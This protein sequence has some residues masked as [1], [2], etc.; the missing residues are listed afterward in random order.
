[1]KTNTFQLKSN[2]QEFETGHIVKNGHP[3]GTRFRKAFSYSNFVKPE[4]FSK[5]VSS[6]QEFNDLIKNSSQNNERESL[7][8]YL[9]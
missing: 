2:E 6:Q 5:Y 7:T 9:Y 3:V 1:M 8:I 4:I